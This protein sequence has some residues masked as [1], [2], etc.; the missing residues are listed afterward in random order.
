[1]RYTSLVEVYEDLAETP[2]TLEKRSRLS[3]LF[4]SADPPL[5]KML[6]RLVR[7]KVFAPWESVEIGVSS[8]LATKAIARSTGIDSD[9][10][11]GWW[12]QEGDLGSAAAKAVNK[13]VQR[14]FDS[15]PLTVTRVYNTIR[16]TA[17]YTGAGSQQR[18]INTIAGLISDATA[19]EAQYVVRTIAG[20]MR[21]GVGEGLI[22][23]ALASAFATESQAD[24]EAVQSAYD[25][26][27]D[28]SIIADRLI[29]DGIEGLSALDIQLFRPVKP[30]LAQK[31]ESI[32]SAHTDLQN[33][34]GQTLAEIKYD[35]VR[36][37]IHV[38]G[39]SQRVFTRRLT[40]IT[41]QFPDVI[42]AVNSHITADKCIIEAEIVGYDPDT[43]D[44]VTF[45]KLSRRI[46]RKHNVAE[47]TSQ[48]P[49][50]VYLFDILYLDGQSMLDAPL[51]RRCHVLESIVDSSPPDIDRA[52]SLQTNSVDQLKSFYAD[53]V[54]SGHEGIMLKNLD[55]PYQPGSR[56]G[57]QRKVKPMMEPL[58]LVV[59]RAKWSEG[60]KS[61]YL[62]RPYLG[63]RG[64][65]GTFYEVGRM[66][67]GF[68]DAELAEFHSQIEPLITEV[69]GREADVRPEVVIEVE[70]EE[71][72]QSSKYD[73][74]YA[75]RFPRFKQLRPDLDA[76]QI[77]SL[78]RIEQLYESQE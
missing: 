54:A 69:D 68:T 65:D 28:F 40:E 19:K 47:M 8:A 46:K 4:E 58:D 73:S 29:S 60:R 78:H 70:Y 15:K 53:A 43:G 16:E 5:L 7:G 34:S 24:I 23:D 31:A 75:L 9:T 38:D 77:D 1:M 30:M 17:D 13:R 44:P 72:Q 12:R 67:T 32:P 22:R 18:Q 2:A 55:Q 35:G 59:T 3:I 6:V 64:T 39:E 51:S 14:T 63:C 76:S 27:N 26:T 62:G 11:E 48:I 74:G 49:V 33:G 52:Q 36:A 66:H 21:I 61:E 37:K 20:S 57:Y 42:S 71:I 41:A 50:S 10:L 25:V 45:Q 56:V